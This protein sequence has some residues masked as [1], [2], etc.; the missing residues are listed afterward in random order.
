M[1]QFF[2]KR[3]LQECFSVNVTAI[4]LAEEPCFDKGQR[5]K[6]YRLAVLLLTG[7]FSTFGQ[8][9]LFLIKYSKMA[10][11]LQFANRYCC[12][13]YYYDHGLFNCVARQTS[14]SLQLHV[15]TVI[16]MYFS[17]PNKQDIF[18]HFSLVV[19]LNLIR[20][21]IINKK[22]LIQQLKTLRTFQCYNVIYILE[23]TLCMYIFKRK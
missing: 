20:Y 18:F 3:L 15:T 9:S 1:V 23:Q 16:N 13:F 8:S 21:G 22:I 2:K 5:V 7:S 4:V 6:R 14:E 12:S 19:S 17:I 10:I 11:Y